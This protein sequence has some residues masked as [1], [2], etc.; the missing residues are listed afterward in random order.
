PREPGFWALLDVVRRIVLGIG[1]KADRPP[2]Y[3]LTR[4][5]GADMAV[6]RFGQAEALVTDRGNGPVDEIKHHLGGAERMPETQVAK[7]PRRAIAAQRQRVL[8]RTPHFR[9]DPLASHL[10]VPRAGAL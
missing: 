6:R 10:E 8:S 5:L 3:D 1:G 4:T 9:R 7:V 2:Q